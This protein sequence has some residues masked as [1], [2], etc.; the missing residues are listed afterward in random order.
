MKNPISIIVVLLFAALW[1]GCK[2]MERQNTSE[3]VILQTDSTETLKN[4]IDTETD[5]YEAS[6][7]NIREYGIIEKIE[8]GAYPF[9]VVTVDF[10]ER[11]MKHDFNLN[12]EDI[13]LDAEGLYNL[14]GKYATIFYT[15]ALEN[16]LIDLHLKGVSL[17][18]EYAPEFDSSWETIT[19]ILSGADEATAGDLPD[20]I[21][22]TA[23]NKKMD[24]DIFI[25]PETV[26]ANGKKVTAYYDVRG[27]ES[28]TDIR[29]S[30]E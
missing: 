10:E 2:N 28:I 16:R 4:D 7:D 23:D 15:S 17:F 30:E 1:I 26:K 14:Q 21:S 29:P 18:G 19:G 3:S 27:V 25:D 12:I 24:F 13:S 5:D 20:T 22:I 6:E 11:N 9:F 8:D